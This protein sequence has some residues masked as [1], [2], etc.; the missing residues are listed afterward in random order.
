MK[1]TVDKYS[2]N[3]KTVEG[4][5]RGSH[6]FEEMEFSFSEE[7]E[8][9]HRT[10]TFFPPKSAAKCISFTGNRVELPAE[11]SARAGRVPYV[12][13][14]ARGG[15][16]LITLSGVI[17]V[18]ENPAPHSA[19][20]LEPTPG[21]LEQVTLLCAEA[22]TDALAAA[23][24]AESAAAMQKEVEANKT[25]VEAMK[26]QIET[27]YDEVKAGIHLHEGI[28]PDSKGDTS[29]GVSAAGV[30]NCINSL[31]P[32][33]CPFRT[34][35]CV[36]LPNK[37]EADRIY[38]YD[39]YPMVYTNLPLNVTLYHWNANYSVG[40]GPVEVYTTAGVPD[41]G[42][43]I[44]WSGTQSPATMEDLYEFGIITAVG[45]Q[46]FTVNGT[47]AFYEQKNASTV[48]KYGDE[49]WLVFDN[50]VDPTPYL[51]ETPILKVI[52]G[53]SA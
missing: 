5:T 27:A 32:L 10:I 16:A 7:W 48:V 12:L 23:A 17:V 37:G 42:D 41:V 29:H 13:C 35:L 40:N 34:E 8:G 2:L 19:E 39:G 3:P 24:S 21:A 18:A 43:C 31:L 45:E 25:E 22:R 53:D 15:G 28:T 20:V 47:V 6:G 30:W 51:K 38:L 14:G 11:V 49:G 50:T 36:Q 46:G 1:I 33:S 44:Y 26:G 52:G 4:G 9:L